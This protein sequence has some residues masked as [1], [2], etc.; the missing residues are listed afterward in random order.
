M[1]AQHPLLRAPGFARALALLMLLAGIVAMHSAVF[2]GPAHPTGPEH[3]AHEPAEPQ[4]TGHLPPA[5]AAAPPPAASH[6][7]A[8]DTHAAAAPAPRHAATPVVPKLATAADATAPPTPA[9][10]H[11]ASDDATA[12]PT[13]TAIHI[14][15]ADAT[16]ARTTPTDQH[17]TGTGC[18]A[19][20]CD[21]HSAVHS[22][23][24]VLVALVLAATL[25]LLYRL[26]DVEAAAARAVRTWRGKRERPPPWTVL[27]LAQLAILR[28]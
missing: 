23:V 10:T 3:A 14:A 18:G 4:R 28:I 25:V 26:T 13:A 21:E 8:T 24:F 5:E 9:A 11:I 6:P 27:T 2:A 17:D 12:P 7:S 22:C 19:A 15:S 1:I 16:A 20:G